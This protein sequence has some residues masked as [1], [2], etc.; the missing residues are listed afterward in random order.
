MLKLYRR[1]KT[2]K[3]SH[4]FLKAWDRIGWDVNRQVIWDG[5]SPLR[6]DKQLDIMLQTHRRRITRREE[7]LDA[8]WN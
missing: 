6:Q 1:N 5:A 3:Y 8:A 4:Q 2:I 7:V